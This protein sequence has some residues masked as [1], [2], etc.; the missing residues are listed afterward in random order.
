MNAPIPLFSFRPGRQLAA[1][2]DEV[3]EYFG[4]TR[5]EFLRLT[6]E[7]GAVAGIARMLATDEH[8]QARFGD[9]LAEAKQS[10]MDRLD[11]LEALA[12]D[13]PNANA[14]LDHLLSMN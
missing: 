3:A 2:F 6:S 9:D 14:A 12:F 13:R 8:V 10:L 5:A 1:S 11:Q 7:M 4:H